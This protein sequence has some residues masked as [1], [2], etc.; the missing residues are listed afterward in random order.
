MLVVG[1]TLSNPVYGALAVAAALLIFLYLA[2]AVMLYFAA[3][4]AV[5]EGAPATQEE[6]AY[7]ARHGADIALPT[8]ESPSRNQ[9]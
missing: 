1:R 8:T 3:W 2:S 5:V 9:P 7:H 4:V 6:L